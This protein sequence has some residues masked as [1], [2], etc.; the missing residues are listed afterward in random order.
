L[1][2][3]ATREL[4]REFDLPVAEKADSQDI[5]FVPDGKYSG[6]VE[7]LHPGAAVP[8]DIVDVDGN[9]LGTHD[10]IIHFTVGQRRGLGISAAHPLYVVRLEP[11]SARVTVGP[12][13]ALKRDR[14]TLRGVN[15]LGLS[16]MGQDGV[17]VQVKL[18]STQPTVAATVYPTGDG[19]ATVTLDEPQTGVAPGQACVF[20]DGDRVLG[21]GWICR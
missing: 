10:G 15:W 8:G 5:C 13:Q 1:D 3:D 12:E 14:L 18:R 19:G 16:E 7:K 21:G 6:V 17:K 20:Y 11:D 9:V 4:A 2:K